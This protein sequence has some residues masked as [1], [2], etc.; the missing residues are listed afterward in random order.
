M[1]YEFQPPGELYDIPEAFSFVLKP[2]RS[3]PTLLRNLVTPAIGGDTIFS[4]GAA[5]YSSLSP[6][7]QRYLESLSAVHSGHEQAKGARGAGQHV[8]REPIETIHPVVRVNPVTGIKSIYIN[9]GFTRRIVGVPKAE[10]DNVLQ[11]LNEQ[12]LVNHDKTWRVKWE[13]DDVVIWDV[14][15]LGC[16]RDRSLMSRIRRTVWS[17]TLRKSAS[18]AVLSTALTCFST[19]PL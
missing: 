6:F 14:S 10:S 11:F 3:G 1:S 15:A 4:S 13:K 2:I 7:Y 16:V 8:R 12:F 9:A 19:Q 18:H 5:I 17:T